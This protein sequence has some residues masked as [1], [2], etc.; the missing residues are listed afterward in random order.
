M[1]STAPS[2][3]YTIVTI[4]LTV[5]GSVCLALMAL[6]AMGV[7]DSGRRYPNADSGGPIV[8]F[9]AIM[10]LGWT[11]LP[12][13]FMTMFWRSRASGSLLLRGQSLRA[14]GEAVGVRPIVRWGGRAA[15]RI[16]MIV[17]VLLIFYQ[18]FA[19]YDALPPEPVFFGQLL[20]FMA[21]TG[22]YA[23]L[24]VRISQRLH[25]RPAPR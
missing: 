19:D 22:T 9:A 25:Q 24:L 3:A 21:W 7:V 6:M 17:A 8:A 23:E 10:L 5:F 15:L 18:F 13:V 1:R 4:C 11:P 20:V 14:I 2:Q 16:L 12:G